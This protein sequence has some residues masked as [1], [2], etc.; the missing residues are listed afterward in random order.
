MNFTHTIRTLSLSLLMLTTA[1]SAS[2]KIKDFSPQGEVRQA[3]QATVVFTDDMVK[4]G[5]TEAASPFDIDCPVDGEGRWTDAKTWKYRFSRP[6]S[7][8]EQCHFKPK[9]TLKALNGDAFEA[10][11]L[12]V[13][14][15]DY[16]LFVPGPWMGDVQPS[17][18]S[19]IDEDQHFVIEPPFAIKPQSILA[20]A[21]CETEGVGER[22]P[23]TVLSASELKTLAK[24]MQWTMTPNAVGLRCQRPLPTGVKMKL[25]WG[26]GIESANG[27][28]TTQNEEKSFKVRQPFRA[29]LSCTRE[30][31]NAPCSPLS[32][33]E[34]RFTDQ[35]PLNLAQKI[36]LVGP[37]GVQ[38]PREVSPE[39]KKELVAK[40]AQAFYQKHGVQSQDYLSSVMFKG[41]FEPNSQLV[42]RLPAKFQDASGRILVNASSFPLKTKIGLLPPLAKFSADFGLLELKEGGV[43][44]VTLRNLESKLGMRVLRKTDVAGMMEVMQDLEHFERQTQ[45]IKLDVTKQTM[46]D[47]YGDEYQP[48]STYTDFYYPRELSFLKDQSGVS[49]E[50]K[51]PKPLGGK[52]FEVVG[53]PLT[54]PGF[55]VVE[56]QS[57]LLGK[58]LLSQAKPM[59]V[60]S[61]ALVTD[62][63][64]H[65]KK[66]R[67]NSVV[68][69]TALSTGKPV[70]DADVSLLD[71]NG[72]VLWAGKTN[73]Q[74]LATNPDP[75]SQAS[76]CTHGYVFYATAKK[77]EDLS[78][79]RSDWDRGIEAWRFNVNTWASSPTVK[80]HTILDRTMLR[81]G[82]TVSMKHIA[83]VP[84]YKGFHYPEERLPNKLTLELIGGDFTE[85]IPVTWDARGVATTQ[86]AIPKDAKLGSYGIRMEGNWEYL[87][88]FRVSEFKL[89][90][91]KGVV[92]SQQ[93]RYAAVNQ[94]PINLSLSYLNG[95]AAN[96]QSVQVSAMLSNAY[97]SFPNYPDFNFNTY[98]GE[99][100]Q[101]LVLDKQEVKLNAQGMGSVK[102]PLSTDP[103]AHF[104]SP[105]SLQT[106]MTFTDANGEVQTIAGTSEVWPAKIAIGLQ[107][108]D[109]AG[110]RGAHKL[111]A[112]ALD[113]AGKP[114]AGV[115]LKIQAE[116]SWDYVHRK[117]IL[118]GFY[119]YETEKNSQDLGTLC[120][121][122][123]DSQ[124]FFQCQV[125]VKE[126]GDVKLTVVG[127]DDEGHENQA[128]SGFSVSEGVDYWFDQADE[129]RM[130]VIPE[131]RE[132]QPGETARFQV[133]TPFYQATALIAVEREG[134]LK[135][136]VQ[137]L[138]R[139]NAVVE[140][141]IEENWG[142]NVFVSVLAVRGR[143]TDV[144]WY[145]FFQWGWHSPIDW[146]KAKWESTPQPTAL[147]DLAKPAY[148]FGLTRINV[149][150]KGFRLNV[151]VTPD[152][153]NY[154][155]RDTVSVKVKVL[156]PNGKP[157]PAGSEVAVAAVD[158]AL[159]ELSPNPTW[160]LLED[161]Q[162][163]RAYMIENA[164]AQMQVVG[165]RHFGKKAL[166]AGGGGG[167]SSTRELFNTLLYWNPRVKL[168]QN[169]M[170]TVRIP[171]ND[172]LTAFKIVAVADVDTGY[173]G[174]GE[175]EISARQDLQIT[176]GLPAMV[177]EGDQ[178]QAMLVLRNATTKP[179]QI[180]LVGKIG[181]ETLKP[182]A[183]TLAAGESK[184]VGW[185]VVVPD[186]V[187]ELPVLLEA[188]AQEGNAQDRIKLTQAVLPRVPATVQ[189]ASFMQLEAPYQINTA[190]PQGAIL[191]KG[192]LEV[193]MTASLA[194]QTAGIERYFHEYPYSCLEQQT[195]IATGLN[196]KQLW[197]NVAN[198]LSSYIDDK[199]FLT[200]F[201]GMRSGSDALTGY[202][203]T[204]AYENKVALPPHVEE[205]MRKALL[206]F[207]EGRQEP[208]TWYWG[209]NRYLVQRRLSA[210]AALSYTGTVTPA[211]LTPF[212]FKPIQMSTPTLMDW[213][214]ILKHVPNAENREEN[215]QAIHRE[216]RNR[217]QN[218]S[219]RLVF[220]HEDSDIYLWAMVDGELN[221]T[222]L[223]TLLMDDPAWKDDMTGLLRGAMMRQ[224]KGRWHTTVSNAWGRLAL[225]KFGETFEHEAVTGKTSVKLNA[226]EKS[227]TWEEGMLASMTKVA[228]PDRADASLYF[229]WPKDKAN[230]QLSIKHD[231]AGKPWINMLVSAAIPAQAKA[232]GY[233]VKRTV[234]AIEQK[235][236][237]Q[238]SRGDLMRVRLEVESDQ[239][240]TWVAL[241]DPIPAGATILGNTARDSVI[242]QSG[243]NKKV[244]VA[245]PS[246]TERGLG[247]FRAY[248]E[249]A[250]QG[251]F[252]Y[253]YTLRLNNPGQFNMPPTRI[254]AM[255]APEVFGQQPNAVV[256]VH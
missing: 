85:E 36:Q 120:E 26:K 211:M 209:S 247:F 151:A 199:G 147:V 216:L 171:L 92:Q 88:Q 65:L 79:V 37:H 190:M 73:A 111:R 84:N 13:G 135:T 58:A 249:Y 24:A 56:I 217:L 52:A 29:E 138:Y 119:S 161:M 213:Y 133:H 62:M 200:Y 208:E 53:I 42:L 163:E 87:A 93:P 108:V 235:V 61:Q 126:A 132:Y 43:L 172:S 40:D 25:V 160:N 97:Y 256:T 41:P 112:I 19:V 229:P 48:P 243:E 77:G 225:K 20:H 94:V 182:Q 255:Y 130:E 170:A 206:D 149:G 168:D 136:M 57:Q 196:D 31:A 186:N 66:G 104:D 38:F 118:G 165:K 205:A 55:Y 99:S 141:P 185:P 145:T 177:R 155:P 180:Q 95:G 195:S 100:L 115:K 89:P 139:R 50:T 173:F 124:G 194:N 98:E 236:K 153:T 223:T 238:W 207:V 18:G 67:D 210:L 230:S 152:K 46:R 68:W 114:Q 156:L 44:P 198:N 54:K 221:A 129:D 60:R 212:E 4:L 103:K 242:A 117:R 174:T 233:R 113:T 241:S 34:L 226:D 64:V 240:M 91:F 105:V 83:R 214:A 121:G 116:R 49:K 224:Q 176:S 193:R 59:Y 251:H 131:H 179:M 51:L 30:K 142:P 27:A 72:D 123:T 78:F 22:I 6:L 70:A 220:D 21:W 7:A 109:W 76:Q 158:R 162:I 96:G 39:R 17:E 231:G 197:A 1:A 222:R 140:I 252:S 204:M 187:S 71:C 232:S 148:K 2:V 125:E 81:A 143:I 191:G 144:P 228:S 159:L 16:Q 102:V 201:P 110:M 246:Y 248:Y 8:G 28:K 82:E 101:D 146:V 15:V 237:G 188:K 164:S 75:M 127:K 12:G 219:G 192:G 202:V 244:G 47:E 106:E 167:R 218:V 183:L 63:A 32:D 90:A 10:S 184:D 181:A 11:T 227:H 33:I 178:Y 14:V 154:R 35:V 175:A 45:E 169:G 245:Y 234:T 215:M 203:L 137:P 122:K 128:T 239:S 9:A 23:V 80:V 69:V 157:A 86:W 166:P 134:V 5:D 254:E 189:Q 107:V 253:E 250:P 3:T 150:T 74:G